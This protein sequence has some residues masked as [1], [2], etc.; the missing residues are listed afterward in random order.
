MTTMDYNIPSGN[1][2]HGLLGFTIA[3]FNYRRV[4]RAEVDQ[5]DK[6]STEIG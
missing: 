2:V 3:M 5:L 6:D 4:K 1:Q